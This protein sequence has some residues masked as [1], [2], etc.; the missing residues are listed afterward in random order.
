MLVTAAALGV[1]GT[2]LLLG[3]WFRA[4]GLATV[5]TM[6]TCALLT[7][8]VA[9]EAPEGSRY[10]EVEWRPTEAPAVQDYRL[11]AGA[12]RLDL[13]KLPL[14]PGQRVAVNAEIWFGELDVTLPK[15]A[16]VE[17]DARV[18][19]GDLGLPGRTI[20]G[21]GAK[22]DLVLE[23]EGPAA[24]GP[25]VIVLRIRGQISDVQVTRA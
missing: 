16:R 23:P 22:A 12:G 4:R 24:A 2:G 1:V 17:I 3:G 6:L 25:P 19:L 5:G 18:R 9:A 11:A 10:G 20:G 21:P 7:S 13:T 8:S 14:R 15:A